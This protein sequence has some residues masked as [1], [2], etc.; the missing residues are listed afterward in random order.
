MAQADVALSKP[1][2]IKVGVPILFAE[3]ARLAFEVVGAVE[4]NGVT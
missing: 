4:P 2:V 1:A 3:V